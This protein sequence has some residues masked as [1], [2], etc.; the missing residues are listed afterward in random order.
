MI[1][2]DNSLPRNR[3]ETREYETNHLPKGASRA[4]NERLLI[5]APDASIENL[6]DLEPDKHRK[7]LCRIR[8]NAARALER[9]HPHAPGP[10][11]TT[12]RIG[13]EGLDP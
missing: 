11:T 10:T 9:I 7:A 5:E 3:L 2:T 12:S 6:A 13:A 4:Q 8:F 1:D